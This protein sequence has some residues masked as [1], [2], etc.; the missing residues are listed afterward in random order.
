MAEIQRTP[1][2]RVAIVSG[3]AQFDA[4][5]DFLPNSGIIVEVSR[6]DSAN[7]GITNLTVG[8]QVA[9]KDVGSPLGNA[10]SEIWRVSNFSGSGKTVVFNLGA[11][12]DHY[13]TCSLIERNDIISLDRTA[14]ASGSG[15]SPSATSAATSFA[16]ESDSTNWQGGAG[17]DKTVSSVGAQTASWTLGT[18]VGWAVAMATYRINAS[19]LVTNAGNIPTAEAF[20]VLTVAGGVAPYNG[21]GMMIGSSTSFVGASMIGSSDVPA[22]GYTVSNAGGIASAEAF[23]TPTLAL[24][25]TIAS[26]GAI[27]S[28]E[29]FGVPTLAL[30]LTITSAGAIASAEAFGT[31][32]VSGGAS[33]TLSN[34]GAIA[35]AEAF[36]VPTLAAGVTVNNVGAIASAEAFGAPALALGAAISNAGAITSA[37]AF[38]VPS[39]IIGATITNAGAIPSAEAFGLPTTS[40]A[41]SATLINVGAIASA[42]AFGTPTL[43]LGATLSNAGAIAS[44][45]AFGVPSIGGATSATLTNVGAIA[46]AEAFGT[47]SVAAGIAISNAGAIAS[48]EAFGIATIS[49]AA[50]GAI[51]NAG[52]IPS[53]EAFGAPTLQLGVTATN[54]GGIA[55][56]E[57]FGIPNIGAAIT[58]T[59]AGAI[60]SAEAFGAPTIT[61]VVAGQII[62]AGGIASAE[63]FG[64]PSIATTGGNNESGGGAFLPRTFGVPIIRNPKKKPALAAGLHQPVRT[65]GIASAEAFGTPTVTGTPGETREQVDARSARE[66]AALAAFMGDI[67]RAAAAQ[68]TTAAIAIATEQRAAHQAWLARDDEEFLNEM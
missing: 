20:G 35:S 52:A 38:G 47:P 18:S 28:A 9:S 7:T 23:G 3:S 24:G 63:A 25:R 51:S 29:A 17:G 43:A 59:G 33:G 61:G 65:E 11:G 15:V 37:E 34:A 45:E 6:F 14:V 58:I 67:Q 4:L 39:L 8:G 21:S 54:A 26:A 36:G 60:P 31:A 5:A 62:G 16:D 41:T 46:S 32:I 66:S 64:I 48:A 30:G 42:E 27:A 49:G 19:P 57:A 22:T 44:A 12:A 10:S 1:K 55:S 13:I 68:L 2:F 50:S 53:S 40:G 56:T